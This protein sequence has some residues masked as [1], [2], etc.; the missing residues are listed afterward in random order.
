MQKAQYAITID[1]PRE[2]VWR[3]ALDDATYR[4]WTREFNAH[5]SW[6]D[7][8]WKTGSKMLFLGPDESGRVGGMVSRISDIRPHEFVSIEH[9]G[10]VHDGKEDTT[11]AMVAQWAPAFENYTFLD[12]D[13][14]TE[15]RVE[16][17]ID[18]AHKARFDEMWPRALQQLKAL[19][20]R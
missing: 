2:S 8:E 4:I 3:T 14:K 15:M 7:G 1:A 16:M 19:A 10:I 9:L 13:G 5:G 12:V 11:S 20:E 17:D 6:Y 18:E